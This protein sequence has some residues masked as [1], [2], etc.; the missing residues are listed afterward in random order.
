MEGRAWVFGDDID[1]DNMFPAR[2]SPDPTP[3]EMAKHVFYD[4]RPEFAKEAKPGDIVVAGHNF[5]YGSYRESP[6]VGMRAL[7]VRLII[8]RSFA[9]AF[10]RNAVTMGIWLVRLGDVE[11][12]CEDGNNL[13]VDPHS[14]MITNQATGEQVWGTPLSGIA[15]E[16]VESGGATHYFKPRVSYPETKQV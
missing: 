4:L 8:A 13:E 3:E 15:Q 16:I 9:R 12:H 2:F 10:Y 6:S 5:G 7:G 1:T 11:F 14:G